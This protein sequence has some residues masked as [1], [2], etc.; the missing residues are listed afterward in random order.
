MIDINYDKCIGCGLCVE[1]CFF[2]A[3]KLEE[4]EIKVNSKRCASCG[5]CIAICPKDAVKAIDLDM[6]EVKEYIKE[7]FDI[8]SENMLNFIKFR[9]SCRDFK[10]E[11]I[12]IEEIKKIIEAGRFTPTASN[13]QDLSYTVIR[14]SIDEIN[15]LGL[16]CL[17]EVG[18]S[19]LN[20]RNNYPKHIIRYATIWIN[21]FEK[22]KEN[23]SEK[24]FLFFNSKTVILI[25]SNSPIDA[26]LAA[27][28][29]EL[30]ANTLGIGVCF[31]GFFIRSINT[32][33][34]LREKLGI[35]SEKTV[36]VAMILGYPTRKYQRTVPRNKADVKFI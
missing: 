11:M 20:D 26:A 31:S 35:D 8:K 14:D 23:P 22:Y 32:S 33:E 29:M 19:I 34:K 17:S 7:D 12:K 18:K 13:K 36:Q 27:S 16:E 2:N 5:H 21:E 15:K 3:L 6:D 4:K 30:M 9:R 28:N 25:S 24:R 1:D 10:D